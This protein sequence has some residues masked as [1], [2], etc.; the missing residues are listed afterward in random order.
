LAS[1]DIAVGSW[2]ERMRHHFWDASANA[3]QAGKTLSIFGGS[4]L[5]PSFSDGFGRSTGDEEFAGG[6]IGLSLGKRFNSRWRTEVELAWRRRDLTVHYYSPFIFGSR[7]SYTR[8]YQLDTFSGMINGYYDFDR[9]PG[10]IV[11]PYI[12]MGLGAAYE[13]FSS[14]SYNSGEAKFAIQVMSGFSI[15]L[16]R[17]DEFYFESRGFT[18]MSRNAYSSDGIDSSTSSELVFGLR[19]TF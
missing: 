6:V 11:T 3:K 14:G 1:E 4:G 5:S 15:H 18:T 17:K 12:G 7:R 8:N 9:G 10:K 19:R 16:S 2:G 13:D